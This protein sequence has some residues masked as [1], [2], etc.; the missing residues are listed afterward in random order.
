MSKYGTKFRDRIDIII[1]S[2]ITNSMSSQKTDRIR[3]YIDPY[4]NNATFPAPLF[5]NFS[6]IK[7]LFQ[8]NT[9]FDVIIKK[10]DLWNLTDRHWHHW[11]QKYIQ[12][13][14]K[15]KTIPINTLFLTKHLLLSQ[16]I[17][18]EMLNEMQNEI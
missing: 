17:K 8:F 15:R 12:Y 11:S 2:L 9:L 3:V 10:F 6:D 14:G 16:N 5:I 13:F 18:T 4:L 1:E 7:N